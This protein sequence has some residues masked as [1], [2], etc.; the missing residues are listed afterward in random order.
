V[1]ECATSGVTARRFAD[2]AIRR[3]RQKAGRVPAYA[4]KVLCAGLPACA[5]TRCRSIMLREYADSAMRVATKAAN[6]AA[7]RGVATHVEPR[8]SARPEVAR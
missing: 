3:C 7:R 4:V 2:M 8:G 6:A 1:P 5:A